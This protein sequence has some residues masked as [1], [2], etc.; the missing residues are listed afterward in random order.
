MSKKIYIPIRAR[1]A[2]EEAFE[3]L[4]KQY[5]RGNEYVA[6]YNG[7]HSRKMSKKFNDYFYSNYSSK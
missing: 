7:K 1:R 3:K 5:S 2:A 4:M 6:F